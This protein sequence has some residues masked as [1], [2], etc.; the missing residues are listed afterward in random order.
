MAFKKGQSGNPGGRG[1]EKVMRDALMLELKREA[2]SGGKT[3]KLQQI[4]EKLVQLA[5]EGDV[6]A[7]KEVFDRIDGR[8]AQAIVGSNDE[9]PIKTVVEIAWVG[10]S[11]SGS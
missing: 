9:P 5:C 7:I 8:P 1:T 2:A 11:G 4:A 6:Q 10:S 3:K